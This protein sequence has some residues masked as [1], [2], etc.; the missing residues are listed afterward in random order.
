MKRIPINPQADRSLEAL[1]GFLADCRREALSDGQARL[2]S[3]S[4]DADHLD[5]L[6]V[7]ESIYEPSDLHFYLE[8][9]A[10]RMALAGAEAVIMREFSGR[11]RFRDAQRFIRATFDR[12]IA[13]GDLDSPPAG[14]RFFCSF[15]FAD[16]DD[17][18]SPFPPATVFVPRWQV[19]RMGD[20]FSAVAN[21]LVEVDSDLEALA[22]RIWRAHGRFRTFGETSPRDPAGSR[23]DVPS[24]AGTAWDPVDVGPPGGYAASVIRALSDIEAGLYRKI[25]LARA[26]DLKT[27][28]DLHPLAALN[29]LRVSYP[30][31][32]SFSVA[33]GRGQSF[34]GATPERLVSLSGRRIRTEALAGS[35]RRGNT[36]LEDAI[37]VRHL[38]RSEK[39]LREQRLVMESIRRRLGNLGIQIDETMRV[40][41]LQL[42]NVQHLHTPI[43]A[44]LPD[45]LDLLRLVEELHPT[46]AVGGTPR[47]A[48][49]RRIAELEPFSRGLYAGPLGWIDADGNGEFVVAIRSALID[50]SKA[51]AYAGAGIVEGSDAEREYGETSL[52]LRALLDNLGVL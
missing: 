28:T 24:I 49:C 8:Q 26:V 9:P 5:P 14:P 7:L 41:V 52:K 51:R 16:G 1:I 15:S 44:E 20:R 13:T 6:A 3:V 50:G 22:G 46:P 10:R 33:N 25:V 30:D 39:D 35:A 4:L 23:P 48:A 31:C 43:E 47:D 21:C 11:E 34:I 2:V 42:S 29:R 18:A 17:P 38:L 27:E 19:V 37:Q 32:F 12:T 40:G 36:A 45:G